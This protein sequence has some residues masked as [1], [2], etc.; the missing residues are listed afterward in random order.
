MVAPPL[1]PTSLLELG[2]KYLL[3]QA[4]TKKWDQGV[5]PPYMCLILLDLAKLKS[6]APRLFIL[7]I[8]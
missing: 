1:Y 5:E 4:P 8:S 7:T 2:L 6:G 3:N